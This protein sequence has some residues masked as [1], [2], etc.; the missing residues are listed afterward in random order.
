MTSAC[1]LHDFVLKSH[2]ES[3]K[4]HAVSGSVSALESYQLVQRTLFFFRHCNFK[5]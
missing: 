1:F 5:G 2:M 4:P 3:S